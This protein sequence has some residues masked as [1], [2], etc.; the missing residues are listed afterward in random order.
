MVQLRAIY[1]E[2]V[3]STLRKIGNAFHPAIGIIG[4]D[5]RAQLRR[6]DLHLDAVDRDLIGVHFAAERDQTEGHAPCRRIR[7]GCVR[8]AS[9]SIP[10]A[11]G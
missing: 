10:C 6:P 8:R 7:V 2:R 5:F 3:P 11:Y 1:L 4:L 9:L